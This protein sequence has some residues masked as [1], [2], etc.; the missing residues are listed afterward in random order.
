MT[1]IL[2]KRSFQLLLASQCISNIGEACRF[3]SIT[4]FLVNTTGSGVSAA[5]GLICAA[6]PALILSPFAGTIGDLLPEKPLLAAVDFFRCFLTLLFLS[7]NNVTGIYVLLIILSITDTL[8]SP[9]RKKIIL[10]IA[11]KKDV[12]TANSLLTGASGAAFLIGPLL[13]GVL[14]DSFGLAPP[15]LINSFTYFLSAVLILSINYGKSAKTMKKTGIAEIRNIYSAMV[16][17]FKY[18]KGRPAI[19]DIVFIC[20]LLSFGMVSMNMSFYPFAFDILRVTAKGWSLMLSIFYGT[21][22]AAMAVVPLITRPGK[23][24]MLPVVFFGTAMTGVIWAL[25]A[26]TRS[27]AVVLLLQFMEG[28]ILAI[29]GIM[30][31]TLLQTLADKNFIARVS[32]VSDLISSACKLAAMFFSFMVLKYADYRVIFIL[33]SALLFLFSFINLFGYIIKVK[34]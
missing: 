4:L 15:F 1:D 27:L 31:G 30:L 33:D 14:A 19:R 22:L 16:A 7:T 24:N 29:C 8:Y 17:G 32:G 3:I 25:Y 20:A 12:L 11:G 5:F 28:T 2:G 26:F 23:S 9:A 6:L 10:V 18:F 21:N 34:R 13:G